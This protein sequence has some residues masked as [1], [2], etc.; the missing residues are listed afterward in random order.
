MQKIIFLPAV[1]VL[2]MALIALNLLNGFYNSLATGFGFSYPYTSY[3]VSSSDI[4]GDLIK[5]ALSLPGG[6]IKD[7]SGWSEL[8]LGYLNNNPYGGVAA[9]NDGQLSNL[10]GMPLPT[11]IGLCIRKLLVIY[12]PN[13]VVAIVLLPIVALYVLGLNCLIKRRGGFIFIISIMTSYPFLMAISRG[14]LVSLMLGIIIIY[15][16]VLAEEGVSW[17]LIAFL[18]AISVNLRPNSIVFLI[19]SLYFLSYKKIIKFA[20]IFFMYALFIFCCSL[21]LANVIYPDYLLGNFLRAVKIYHKIYILGDAGL[22]FGSSFFGG[23]RFLQ[24]HL[25]GSGEIKFLEYGTLFL[26]LV[27]TSL[28]IFVSRYKEIDFRNIVFCVLCVY[29]LF[30]GTFADYHLIPFFSLLILAER[31]K[32]G[33][34]TGLGI[35]NLQY[36][37]ALMVLSAKNYIF[38]NF[39]LSAQV[40]INPLVLSIV[41]AVT[42]YFC[43]ALVVQKWNHNL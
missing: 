20:T 14:H 12:N 32:E 1:Y 23:L 10:H 25:G 19:V 7:L 42:L 33:V 38:L 34:M 39:G 22:A 37:A 15:V 28:L 3:L 31:E 40:L 36:I 6:D 4:F 17:H 2:P 21:L 13:S 11:L 5:T 9:L 8:Y 26:G 16:L 43:I 35:K 29:T 27:S 24:L 41:L 18:L 30:T